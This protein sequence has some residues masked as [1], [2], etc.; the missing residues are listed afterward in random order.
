[1]RLG[2]G[3][4]LTWGAYDHLVGDGGLR[5]T[6]DGEYQTLNPMIENRCTADLKALCEAWVREDDG[7]ACVMC[8]AYRRERWE[9]R[10]PT[11]THDNLS[12]SPH[13]RRA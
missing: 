11:I 13:G 9:V 8:V 4:D 7:R 12:M 10:K 1:M 3:Y 5:E 6:V 2:V